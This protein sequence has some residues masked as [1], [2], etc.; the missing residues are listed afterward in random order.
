ME[1][2][3]CP[4]CGE[5]T[6]L[7]Y[8]KYP[9]KDGLCSKHAKRLKDGE[10]VQCPDCGKWNDKDKGCKCKQQNK[11]KDDLKEINNVCVIC[12]RPSNGKEF[13]SNCYSKIQ[14]SLKTI[15]KNEYYFSLKDHYYNL[16]SSIFR[17]SNKKYVKTNLY[18]L[19]AIAWA[20]KIYHK[21]NDLDER[22][23]DDVKYVLETKKINVDK[24]GEELNDQNN[25]STP[26]EIIEDKIY[27]AAANIKENRAIDGHLCL[28]PQ[29]VSI[30]DYL[31]QNEIV[32]AYNKPVKEIPETERAVIAD[33]FIPISTKG[34]GKG[35]YIEYW[36]I[37]D[38]EDYEENKKEK[39]P[40]YEKYEVPLIQINKNDIKDT[41]TLET[42]L[43]RKLK[44]NGYPL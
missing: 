20:M 12:G 35:V 29:E 10:I 40:L 43:Y 21:N 26:Q 17:I 11:A 7:V 9:R 32:H 22:V 30:D 24:T 1:E 18:R 16:K 14:E 3:K 42:V 23:I 2:L 15:N 31:Y 37:D 44:E 4:I 6:Y 19:I 38:D 25:N 41:Q 39:L 33:W 34:K 8:G 36:G 28:S 13:C 27:V 5:P